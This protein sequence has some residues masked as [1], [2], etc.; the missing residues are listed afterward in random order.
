[1]LLVMHKINHGNYVNVSIINKILVNSLVFICLFGASACVGGLG[2]FPKKEYYSKIETANLEKIKISYSYFSPKE[3]SCLKITFEIRDKTVLDE[4]QKA[5]KL[6][7]VSSYTLGLSSPFQ[8]IE[9]DVN[10]KIYCWKIQFRKNKNEIILSRND[11]TC[12]AKLKDDTLYKTALKYALKNNQKLF[13][14]STIDEVR[15]CDY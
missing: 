3:V 7:N 10:G 12:A 2:L 13:P 1:M 9:K 15:L 8:F 5:V 6:D 11:A 4:F 14:N